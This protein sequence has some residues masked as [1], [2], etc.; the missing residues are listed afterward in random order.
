M[1]RDDTNNVPL[2]QLEMK[3]PNTL[4]L[5]LKKK[6]KM[7]NRRLTRNVNPNL[8]INPLKLKDETIT[9]T[10]DKR[11]LEGKR[12]KKRK[13][14]KNIDKTIDKDLNEPLVTKK[15]KIS[16]TADKLDNKKG[17][18]EGGDFSITQNACIKKLDKG[19]TEDS[20][21]QESVIVGMVLTTSKKEEK[22]KAES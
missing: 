20:S 12:M 21:K 5:S 19:G 9:K 4:N 6:G 8:T 18:T 13:H 7:K 10:D 11:L 22:V 17:N 16:V 1:R 14:G 15:G 2:D 3:R